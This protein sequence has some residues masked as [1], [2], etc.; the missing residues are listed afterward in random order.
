MKAM[1]FLFVLFKS[2][3]TY[4]FVNIPQVY[5]QIFPSP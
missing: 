1:C 4:V 3:N 2:G 5:I